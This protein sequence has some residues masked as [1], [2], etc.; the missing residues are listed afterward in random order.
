MDRQ[1]ADLCH[2]YAV[3]VDRISEILSIINSRKDPPSRSGSVSFPPGND[4]RIKKTYAHYSCPVRQAEESIERTGCKL[5]LKKHAELKNGHYYFDSR[6][7]RLTGLHLL[8]FYAYGILNGG[9]ATS[10]TD[11]KKNYAFNSNLFKALKEPFRKMSDY[12]AGRTKS[13]TPA[14]LNSDYSGGYSFIELK[15]RNILLLVEEYT[16]RIGKFPSFGLPVFQMTS[17]ANTGEVADFQ[18]DLAQ[19]PL[20]EK[21]IRKCSFNPIP[22][23]TATQPLLAAM[24]PADSGTERSIFVYTE[25]GKKHILPLPGGHGES[26]NTLKTIYRTMYGNGIRFAGLGNSDNLGSTIEPAELAIMAL[27]GAP[28]GFE[29]SP[30]T[31]IDI[32]GGVLVCKGTSQLSCV[33]IGAGISPEQ[34]NQAEQNKQPV[35]FNCANGIFNLDF[36]TAN[37]DAIRNNIPVRISEQDKDI[38][39]Y[40]QAEQITWEVL[41]LIDN[42]LI[43]RVS[44]FKRFLASKLLLENLITTGW[45]RVYIE[46]TMNNSILASMSRELYAAFASKMKK[47]Y[48]MKLRKDRWE[49]V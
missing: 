41:Q 46:K 4:P 47:E 28:A 1:L 3:S 12:S 13:C 42:P 17:Q 49:P 23:L 30:K 40:A 10:Y 25:N 15:L 33:D 11:H 8:P 24:T 29:F 18:K 48:R 14:W 45:G 21:L 43:F 39:K 9:S 44:K 38:G 26:F 7:L 35:L 2:E 27:S 16:D 37:I 6:Q 20:I 32:K 5:V 36:L 31:A 19:S 22:L 34:I